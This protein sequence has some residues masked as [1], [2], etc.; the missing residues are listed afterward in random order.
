M[1]QWIHERA[2]HLLAKNPEMDTGMAFGIA[3]QQSHALGKS[4]KNFGT[5]KGRLKAKKKYDEPGKMTKTP[6]PGKL[7]TEKLAFVEALPVI[8]GLASGY[9]PG[10]NIAGEVAAAAAPKG[11]IHRSDNI[12]RNAAVIGV[13][14]GGLAAMALA[15]K[16]HL[17]PRISDF[18]AKHFPGGL[19]SEPESERELFRQLLPGAAAI[20]GSLA[21]GA[22]T[23]GIVGAF[24][25]L[26]GPG[27]HH[28]P[29][30][31]ALKEPVDRPNADRLAALGVGSSVASGI[32]MEGFTGSLQEAAKREIA[33][34]GTK[35]LYDKVL[36]NAPVQVGHTPQVPSAAFIP[37]GLNSRGVYERAGLGHIDPNLPHVLVNPEMGGAP[38]VLSHELGH[39]DIH[40]SRAGRVLQSHLAGSL[41]R[42][43]PFVGLVGG[44]ATGDSDNETVRNLGMASGAIAS[45]PQLLSEAGASIKGYRQLKRLGANAGQLR[46]ARGSL[47]PAFGT[48]LASAGMGLGAGLLG[49]GA[50]R[51]FGNQVRREDYDIARRRGE[52]EDAEFGDER[53]PQIAKAA[54]DANQYSGVMNPPAMVYKSGIP[55]WQEQ[56]VKT[57]GPPS[58]L[59]PKTAGRLKSASELSG[60]EREVGHGGNAEL[61][62]LTSLAVRVA[63]DARPILRKYLPGGTHDDSK[64]AAAGL[65]PLSRL[66]TTT[67]VGA[68]KVS[69]P[70]GP[71]IAQISK[72]TGYGRPISGAAKGNHII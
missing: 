48:Y 68:P 25:H 21:G 17:A 10:R 9:G 45:I 47:L 6:N 22:A 8:T 30:T 28:Q 13:P 57:A 38:S 53:E 15:H 34:P 39:A 5:H 14:L 12:A 64:E 2:K 32:G 66:N 44:L 1:P 35:E 55:P 11:R 41:G 71:S 43:S 42:H 16:Y 58:E 56:P 65:T 4:P 7:K 31:A 51:A 49:S 37:S 52:K 24:Q 63:D 29:K 20:G 46:A 70:P 60:L 72:P 50:R 62:K 33:D 61:Q 59:K 67:S 27:G 19:I 3:T 40:S 26:R 69:T 36:S 23:G 18:A 54:F